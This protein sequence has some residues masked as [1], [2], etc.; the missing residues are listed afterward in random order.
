ML[1]NIRECMLEKMK[2]V[3]EKCVHDKDATLPN[4]PKG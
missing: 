1:K 2:P 4:F 3:M